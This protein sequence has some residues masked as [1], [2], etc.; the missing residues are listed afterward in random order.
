MSVLQLLNQVKYLGIDL[1]VESGD[2]LRF[3]AEKGIMTEELKIQIRKYKQ[4]IIAIFNQM[5]SQSIDR[6]LDEAIQTAPIDAEPQLSFAQERLWFIDQ[7]QPGNLIYLISKGLLLKGNLNIS[8]LERCIGK[9]IERQE[10]LRTAFLLHVGKPRL[11]IEPFVDDRLN[12]VDLSE[13]SQDQKQPVLQSLF[14]RVATKP[15]D[16]SR[17][18]AFRILLARQSQDEHALLLMI[19][20][21]IA[22]DW[23]IGIFI[24]EL[25][26]LYSA[27]S[28]GLP[29]PLKPLRIQYKD[30]AYQQR[31]QSDVLL[32]P[33]LAYWQELLNGLPELGLPT[34]FP[35]P[36][37][38]SHRGANYAFSIPERTYS[39]L[40][41]LATRNGASLYMVLLATFNILLSKF[42]RQTD[43][44]ICT[45]VG[46]R[47]KIE[48]EDIIGLFV[49]LIVLRNKVDENTSFETFLAEVKAV[50]LAGFS[51]VDA[52]FEK[53][54]EK[55]RAKRDLG[56]HPLAQVQMIFTSAPK[57]NMA[58]DGLEI[59]PLPG[60]SGIAKMDLTLGFNETS[61]GLQAGFEYSLDLFKEP[62]IARIAAYLTDLLTRVANGSHTPISRLSRLIDKDQQLWREMNRITTAYPRDLTIAPLFQ[63]Q[64][65]FH[66]DTPALL[67]GEE[68]WTYEY[69]DRLTDRIAA[70][71]YDV[72]V[73][74]GD[75]VGL[76]LTSGPSAVISMLA[77]LKL[78]A[79]YIPIDSD[80]PSG[81]IDFMLEDAG[82]FF[83]IADSQTIDS[84]P[85]FQLNF[86]TA[87]V[88][89]EFMAELPGDTTYPVD[90]ASSMD[91]AYIMYTSGST[92]RPKGVIVSHRNIVRLVK[93]T[94][95]L[96]PGP[97]SV[98]IQASS[99]SFDAATF[100]I[101]S[102]LLNGGTLTFAPGKDLDRLGAQLRRYKVDTLWLTA[103]LFHIMVDDFL[104]DLSGIKYL[105][106]GGDVL[107]LKHCQAFLDAYPESRLING[108]GPTEST[109]F[110][111]CCDLREH[112]F[113]N[114]SVSIGTPIANTSIY[115]I[116]HRED[117]V[118][119]GVPGELCIGGDGLSR[120]YLNHPAMTAEKFKPNP[121][122]TNPTDESRLYHTGDMARLL[123]NGLIEFLG[124]RDNQVKIRGFRIELD[125]IIA[126][127][128]TC[129][130]V[131]EAVVL[132][133]QNGDRKRLVAYLVPDHKK[134]EVSQI[135]NTLQQRLPD[136]MIPAIF[137]FLDE[138]P[139]TSQGK[140]DRK[141]LA[142]LDC[143]GLVEH[144]RKRMARNEK[145]R[146]LV[147]AW[148]EILR[149]PTV[150]IDDN[151]FD[152]GG[153][154]LISL[155]IKAKVGKQGLYFE[156][157]A[158]FEHPTIASLGKHCELHW[159]EDAAYC[160]FSLIPLG[161]K[162]RMPDHVEDAFPLSHLQLGMLFHSAFSS[163]SAFYHDI[164]YYDLA[165]PFHE[166]KIKAAL[167]DLAHR[168]E[169]LRLAFDM[170]TYSLPLQLVYR[171]AEIPLQVTD[172]CEI[173]N[174]SDV[175]DTWLSREKRKSF[176]WRK[177][178]LF[179][180]FIHLNPAGFRCSF[181][182]HHAVLDG[183]SEASMFMV[184]LKQLLAVETAPATTLPS[185]RL[186]RF[187]QLERQI[188]NDPEAISFWD[189]F[190]AEKPETSLAS[191]AEHPDS[192]REEQ[193]RHAIVI[194]PDTS[195]RLHDLAKKQ[196]A[197]LKSILMAVHFR[198]LSLLSGELEVITGVIANGRPEE[199]GGDQL[200][201]LFLNALP[202]RFTLCDETWRQMI[203]RVLKLETSIMPYRRFPLPIL[204]QRQG[205]RK[206]FDTNFNFTHFHVLNN[207]KSVGAAQI[208]TGRGGASE[209]SM[210]F[211]MDFAITPGSDRIQGS[212]GYDRRLFSKQRIELIG[213]TYLQVL[214]AMAL[215]PGHSCLSGNLLLEE[216]KRLLAAWNDTDRNYVTDC[217]YHKVFENLSRRDPK[218]ICIVHGDARYSREELNRRANCL[219]R[220]IRERGVK[221][222]DH[223]GL[224]LERGI[225]FPIALLAV[226]KAGAAYLPLNPEEAPGRL[227][228]II[229]DASPK[230]VLTCAE[231]I[232]MPSG[233]NA[234]PIVASIKT[235][236]R[237]DVN[238]DIASN[239]AATAYCIYT[240]GSTGKP[241]GVC[242]PHTA[243]MNF[244]HEIQ[245]QYGLTARDRVLQFC[246]S[247]FDMSVKEINVTLACD[248]VL[249]LH[250]HGHGLSPKELNQ[251]IRQRRITILI[252]PTAYWHQW[253][254]TFQ[255]GEEPEFPDLRLVNTGGEQPGKSTV[256]RWLK[257]SG[258]HAEWI[259]TYGPTET[260][261]V[262]TMYHHGDGE[263]FNCIPMGRPLSN[264]RVHVLDQNGMP[265]PIGAPG[266]L[267]IAGKGLASGYLRR[268]VMTALCFQPNPF[269]ARPGE[270]LY[271]TGDRVYFQPD[272]NL[273]FI[274][275][276]DNQVKLRGFRIELGEIETA[277]TTLPGVSSAAARVVE[278]A[279]VRLLIG[280]AV[281]LGYE[282][283]TLKNLLR[284]RLPEYML[285]SRIVFLERMPMLAG[286]KIDRKRLPEAVDH[287]D[288]DRIAPRTSTEHRLST[289]WREILGISEVCVHN[290]FFELGGNSISALRLISRIESLFNAPFPIAVIYR[291][292]TLEALASHLDSRQ[293]P[294]ALLPIETRVSHP[295]WFAMHPVGGEVHWYFDLGKAL[296]NWAAL[297]GVQ[298]TH[299]RCI[300]IDPHD[301][302]RSTVRA[303]V[304]L[305]EENRQCEPYR[306]MGWSVGGAIAMEVALQL[307]A[308]GRDVAELVLIDSVPL[309][310]VS[311][312]DLVELMTAFVVDRIGF[313]SPFLK[314]IPRNLPKEKIL[315]AFHDAM[316]AQ[317]LIPPEFSVGMLGRMFDIYTFFHHAAAGYLPD[318]QFKG[319]T[320]LIVTKD[321]KR[322]AEEGQWGDLPAGLGWQPF[323]ARLMRIHHVS[324]HHY[325]VL[326][327]DRLSE[328]IHLIR[329]SS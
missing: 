279:G 163:D 180:V 75:R 271:R 21:I 78:G 106:A 142:R 291:H 225:H 222:G 42:S 160:P 192:S 264:V 83:F 25:T 184:F 302:L 261:V 305:L 76:C 1:W 129:P 40:K 155:Q 11:A 324:G 86:L 98:F 49:N 191:K 162:E 294:S 59:L 183:W 175:Y 288:G 313:L 55:C 145:E 270:R 9:I 254:D 87:L 301:G 292:P 165:M 306:L 206:L 282:E 187:I 153:D 328:W 308:A 233:I 255:S 235:D 286:G 202:Y 304:A 20:H 321:T 226:L 100:E 146:I 295:T 253:V 85:A 161:D 228:T 10:S 195:Q 189:K 28:K 273:V 194:S 158:I 103:Q 237:D 247:I 248:A 182:F 74:R 13:L 12:L 168:H 4:E 57:S 54:V 89:E 200:L 47:N 211:V 209:N 298:A 267:Y 251:L 64:A 45:S 224:L 79:A 203:V 8:I 77:V 171:T 252:M 326:S 119:V 166:Q 70:Y 5:S 27:L 63:Q 71:L 169:A 58:L 215:N 88:Y 272:G 234:M 323:C 73:D 141:A 207:L 268:P 274:G 33:Q 205:G 244:V 269:T 280:Y 318:A 260:T 296:E 3:R 118:P 66:P 69:L 289:I 113:A 133:K 309:P 147:D 154:S 120:G 61:A 178:P 91:T 150:C 221:Q 17:A 143:A 151:F 190:L 250:P 94:N 185:L 315:T 201:G 72:G 96:K 43:I 139:A 46:N 148:Q 283:R 109:T 210:G 36:S 172:L 24:R 173:P 284:D 179:Q 193:A 127:L 196:N 177:P 325:D 111:C 60:K 53:V 239:P 278:K 231:S 285:P 312:T 124:R 310:P 114:F 213:D 56:R 136:Y 31:A 144:S 281:A 107:S 35:R 105:L 311:D 65:A 319:Q 152:L 299:E 68:I 198:T 112:G 214:E 104:E 15:F 275:R 132:A 50:T 140:I 16:L 51:N 108:Y 199:E 92:G 44:G 259:N 223:V 314:E 34:D 229:E 164:I 37:K 245:R 23:S 2:R 167:A 176:D 256:S 149:V 320:T 52:P 236:N 130:G 262:A 246:A 204:I 266:M 322:R 19:H 121:F 241:K 29:S 258:R 81:H 6:F 99:V 14:T 265:A 243:L 26:V 116:D 95:Y 188:M 125:E 174:W 90:Q 316:A 84:L 93:E 217:C 290:N 240:S 39:Q 117:L 303:Y 115:I 257:T 238:P 134:T 276:R 62:T 297:Y 300:G 263:I 277:M 48:L 232:V 18:P 80:Y 32:E 110:A 249:A 219:A 138:L 41:A 242:I 131:R 181:S 101:W 30:F 218:H 287:P 216:H 157:Q 7:L 22:D 197:P 307:Q 102:P 135:K 67:A 230:M 186:G 159:E 38:Q 82:I 327:A 208:I 227:N 156:L 122:V 128:N 126:S 212:L 170:D 293:T 123:D 137:V 329:P 317:S 97:G 220:K